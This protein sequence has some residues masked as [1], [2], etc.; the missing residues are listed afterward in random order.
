MVENYHSKQG[1][2]RAAKGRECQKDDLRDTPA[3]VLRTV[4]VPSESRKSSDID[5]DKVDLE[6]KID[7]WYTHRNQF[8]LI[9]LTPVFAYSARVFCSTITF[10]LPVEAW[11]KCILPSAPVHAMPTWVMSSPPTVDT[12]ARM[13]P[14]L[15]WLATF[16]S[17]RRAWAIE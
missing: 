9:T 6:K 13:S 15:I 7:L 12:N 8:N 1:S 14:F 3:T 5:D 10:M 17:D 2:S 11:I 4:F 16:G